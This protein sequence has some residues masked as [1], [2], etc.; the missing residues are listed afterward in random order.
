MNPVEWFHT[1][2]KVFDKITV[3]KSGDFVFP[4]L[5][6]AQRLK[7]LNTAPCDRT[8]LSFMLRGVSEGSKTFESRPDIIYL[9]EQ[10][11]HELGDSDA[12]ETIRWIESCEE[13]SRWIWRNTG[14]AA[15]RLF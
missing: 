12:A 15:V 13:Y 2:T 10:L 14:A 8:T 6:E 4:A 9:C 3:A 11:L 5:A 7:L 1:P